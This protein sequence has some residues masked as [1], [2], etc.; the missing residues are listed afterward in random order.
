MPHLPAQEARTARHLIAVEAGLPHGWL[1]GLLDRL[2]QR[3]AHPLVGVDRKHPVATGERK[4]EVL[5]RAETM[6]IRP[7]NARPLGAGDLGSTVDAVAIDHDAL[8]AEGERVQA[9]AD[10]PRLLL[11]ADDPPHPRPLPLPLFLR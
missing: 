3:G 6:P 1:D 4:R 7:G 11:A 10:I 8:V 2:P 9:V 5:L